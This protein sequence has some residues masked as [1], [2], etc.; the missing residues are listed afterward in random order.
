MKKNIS[1]SIFAFFSFLFLFCFTNSVT[2]ENQS[3]DQRLTDCL[4]KNWSVDPHTTVYIR[5][6]FQSLIENSNFHP[7][8]EDFI[9]KS[10]SLNIDFSPNRG[11]FPLPCEDG[12]LKAPK[13]HLVVF[14]NPYI[15]ILLDSTL[16]GEYEDFHVHAW[17]SLMVVI[18]PTTYK[19]DYLNGVSETGFWPVGV[20]EL[21][22]GEHYAC[23]N[24]G[25][26]VDLCLRFEIK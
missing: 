7:I 11:I 21:P 6:K 2:A 24:V 12:I 26:T 13:Q 25:D 4:N 9:A 14:E 1:L 18:E 10:Q 20:Y 5:N 8:I 23:T 22:A 3:I 16:P 19:I 17:K 15:R